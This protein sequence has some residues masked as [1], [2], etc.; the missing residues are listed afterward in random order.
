MKTQQEAFGR[1][2][3][4]VL[5]V[6]GFQNSGKTTFV[7]KLIQQL[8]NENWQVATIKHHGHGGK[9]DYPIGKD[10]SRH[11]KA[12]ALASLVEGEGRLIVHVENHPISLRQQIEL[13]ANL[14]IDFL[15]IEGHKFED[16]PKVLLVRNKDDEELVSRLT[17]IKA[18]FY[19]QE[20]VLLAEKEIP[21]FHIND[22]RGLSWL[23]E[24][25]GTMREVA[26]NLM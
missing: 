17:N 24:Q 6:V 5:Q 15:I 25:L 14:P 2:K 19:W 18:I 22:E 11:I 1:G 9:P 16:Y 7:T 13:L 3:P 20:Q 8:V 12:G 26:L 4:F 21:Q 23:V 10:S